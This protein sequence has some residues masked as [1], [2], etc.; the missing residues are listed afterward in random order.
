[1]SIRQATHGASSAVSSA[2]NNR[3]QWSVQLVKDIFGEFIVAHLQCL[4]YGLLCCLYLQ[5]V[6]ISIMY[7]E[8][9]AESPQWRFH[10]E[11]GLRTLLFK[12]LTLLPSSEAV[13][14]ATDEAVVT[15]DLLSA[16]AGAWRVPFRRSGERGVNPL[17][18]S[19]G[20]SVRALALHRGMQ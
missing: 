19:I 15:A 7:H 11:R 5:H 12:A 6:G 4:L 9:T 3:A 20:R 16:D 1:M 14:A 18:E 17:S 2:F 8:S 10:D 13:C